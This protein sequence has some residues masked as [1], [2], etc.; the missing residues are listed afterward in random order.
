MTNFGL[1]S[2]EVEQ[3]TCRSNRMITDQQHPFVVVEPGAAGVM[4]PEIAE[5]VALDEQVGLRGNLADDLFP[6][7]LAFLTGVLL[8]LPS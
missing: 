2:S 3:G 6:S 7:G 1:L 5:V 8:R 4:S